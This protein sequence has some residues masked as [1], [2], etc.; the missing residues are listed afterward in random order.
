L[1]SLRK[2]KAAKDLESK[3]L[4]AVRISYDILKT[5]NPSIFKYGCIFWVAE[6]IQLSI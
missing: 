2:P 3:G 4:R 5:G 1:I 6:E